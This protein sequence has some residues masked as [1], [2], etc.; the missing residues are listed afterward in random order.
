MTIQRPLTDAENSV[1][2]KGEVLANDLFQ[3]SLQQHSLV[4]TG[5]NTPH[6]RTEISKASAPCRDCG[7]PTTKNS[8]GDDVCQNPKCFA[9]QNENPEI[10]KAHQGPPCQGCGQPLSKNPQ[11]DM[12]CDTLGCPATQVGKAEGFN[13]THEHPGM[14]GGSH[15]HEYGQGHA[16]AATDQ[17][18]YEFNR[19]WREEQGSP[20][21]GD[22]KVDNHNQPGDH[23]T[24]PATDEDEGAWEPSGE[25]YEQAVNEIVEQQAHRPKGSGSLT[26]Y[27]PGRKPGAKVD[28]HED[29]Q[30]S[31]AHHKQGGNASGMEHTHLGNQEGSVPEE[32]HAHPGYG[33]ADQHGHYE[34]KPYRIAQ[35][36]AA[37][38]GGWRSEA[39]RRQDQQTSRRRERRAGSKSD[40]EDPDFSGSQNGEAPGAIANP[41]PL[42]Q[43]HGGQRPQGHNFGSDD[44]RGGGQGR[45]DVRRQFVG[46]QRGSSPMSGGHPEFDRPLSSA[47]EPDFSG[48]GGHETSAPRGIPGSGKGQTSSFRGPPD[49]GAS[50]GGKVDHPTRTSSGSPVTR[51]GPFDRALRKA[52]R[53]AI[54]EELSTAQSPYEFSGRQHDRPTPPNAWKEGS[55]FNPD[56]PE[57][58]PER[59]LNGGHFLTGQKIE[60]E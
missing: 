11:G 10:G 39:T 59:P 46:P 36:G 20:P 1:L 12:V 3:F 7:Q 42:A 50:F 8:Y 47:E 56:Q 53:D 19:P 43:S 14:P 52:I 27:K 9:A 26:M 18:H 4:G 15:S 35:T 34:G 31:T 30:G 38:A 2:A 55:E 57:E 25:E 49:P 40:S 13:G 29:A 6:D 28:N 60:R 22:A 23:G 24:Q 51:V 54:T 48:A 45:K 17:R 33:N 37:S 5:E 58:K 41:H 21:P 44:Q 16:N 32:T